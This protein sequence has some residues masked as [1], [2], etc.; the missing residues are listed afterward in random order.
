MGHDDDDELIHENFNSRLGFT[1]THQK[2]EM[3]RD[4]GY[5]GLSRH[6]GSDGG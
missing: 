5:F 6:C 3:Q 1:F 2:D 4:Q